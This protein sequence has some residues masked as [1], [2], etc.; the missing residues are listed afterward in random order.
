MLDLFLFACCRGYFFI[1][2][3]QLLTG[4]IGN[5]QSVIGKV[6]EI[7]GPMNQVYFTIKPQ[8]GIVAGSFKEGDKF[9]IGGDKLLPL[10][11]CVISLL[12]LLPTLGIH[13]WLVL[14]D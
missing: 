2:E 12:P 1:L 7:L 6:D 13:A 8:D 10:D 11:R 14:G 4:S 9:Y 3:K 5:P